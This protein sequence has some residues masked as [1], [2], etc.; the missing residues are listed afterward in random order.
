MIGSHSA[1]TVGESSLNKYINAGIETKAKSELEKLLA[2]IKAIKCHGIMNVYDVINKLI[3]ALGLV[4]GSITH[5]YAP[6]GDDMTKIKEDIANCSGD[7]SKIEG[8]LDKYYDSDKKVEKPFSAADQT[9]LNGDFKDLKDHMTTFKNDKDDFDTFLKTISTSKYAT[10]DDRAIVAR[11][12]GPTGSVDKIYKDFFDTPESALTAPD[13]PSPTP[14]PISLSDAIAEAVKSGSYDRISTEFG[15]DFATNKKGDT[16]SSSLVETLNKQA[17]SGNID[18]SAGA[19]EVY[20][21]Q[22]QKASEYSSVFQACS[23]FVKSTV[24]FL[25]TIVRN[26]K[27]Q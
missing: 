24:D 21:K 15:T 11:Y 17:A 1:K 8:I 26:F 25:G 9:A 10:S 5:V 13:D 2:E 20:T 27:S 6:F 22:G 4:A 18:V 14:A 3:A 16:L 23:G 19:T 12:A 7:V